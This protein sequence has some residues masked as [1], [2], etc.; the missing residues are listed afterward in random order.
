MARAVAACRFASA[1]RRRRLSERWANALPKH[2]HNTLFPEI[3]RG[4]YFDRDFPFHGLKRLLGAADVSKAGDR[5]AG[6]AAAGETER[7]VARTILSG[8][9]LRHLYDHPLTDDDGNVD[10]VMTVNYDIDR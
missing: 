6:L 2:C 7:E 4:R 1:A 9:T 10:S 8:L 3:F 5:N